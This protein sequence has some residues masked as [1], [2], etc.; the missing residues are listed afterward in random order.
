M[1]KKLILFLSIIVIAA[2]QTGV[3]AK[4]PVNKDLVT[5]INMYKVGNY[6]EC[7][8]NLNNVIKKDPSNAVAYYYLGMTSA[9]IGRK[10][11]AIIN[12]ERAISLSST[13]SNINRYATKGKTCL[14]TP[15]K[16]TDSVYT[17]TIDEFVLNQNS[18]KFSEEV[19]GEFEKLKIEN[20]KRE[21]NRNKDIDRN[22]F[23]EYRDFSS[24]NET[25]PS[26]DEIVAALRVLQNAGFNNVLNTPQSELSLLTGNN[27]SLMNL[28][29]NG[30][31]NP[32][33]L[34]TLLTNN[35]TLGF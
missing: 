31:V 9:Q 8:A 34:Q 7:Y 33:V 21:I 26:N 5:A 16:C 27:D 17:S 20:L 23:K 22:R 24:M 18:S 12:Y 6:T 35:M 28:M 10:Q 14:E 1:K 11:E 15:E 32:Q 29:G 25:T 4:T 3:N 19:K 2:L 30:Q 13:N